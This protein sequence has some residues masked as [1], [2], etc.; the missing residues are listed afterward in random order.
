M[1]YTIMYDPHPK[2]VEMEILTQGIAAEAKRK[3]NLAPI[4]SYAFYIR[5]ENNTIIGGSSGIMYY[6]CLYIDQ[7]WL[8]E[9]I[10]RQGYGTQLM[11]RTEQLAKQQGCSFATVNTMD[12]EAFEFYKKL[13][14]AIEHLRYGYLQNSFIYFLR[15]DL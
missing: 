1:P 14:Y 2:Q 15:K 10:R 12:W 3:R 6:G 8:A 13:G 5:D 9:K 11:A 7:L 4:E